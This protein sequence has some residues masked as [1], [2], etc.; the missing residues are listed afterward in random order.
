MLP[1]RDSRLTRIAL[2][3]FFIVVIGYAYF[4]ARGLLFGP[5]ID[6]PSQTM[7]ETQ[8]PYV[9]IQGQANRIASLS[10]DG[11]PLQVTEAGDFQEPYVLAPGVNR[12]VFDAKDK[13]GNATQKVVEIVYTPGA[14]SGLATA[15]S[16]FS[17]QVASQAADGTT[18]AQVVA[19]TS[20]IAPTQ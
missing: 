2:I 6:I 20:P 18:T 17:A 8:D 10:V 7:T 9:L 15:P 19:S 12:I 1:Y 4:E 16:A 3:I 5:M 14:T 11:E 13:Y